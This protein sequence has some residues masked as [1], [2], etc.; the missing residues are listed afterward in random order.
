MQELGT[1]KSGAMNRAFRGLLTEFFLQLPREEIVVDIKRL[2][3]PVVI[4]ISV[5]VLP[6][7]YL[8]VLPRGTRFR[9]ST[10]TIL[11]G[12]KGPGSAAAR[13][14]GQVGRRDC[15]RRP[16][17]GART[18]PACCKFLPLRQWRTE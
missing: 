9:S 5:V 6:A 12:C 1:E 18:K 3:T 16:Q 15:M 14:S 11:G 2:F 13:G 10:C 8:L 17:L 7:A 4:P